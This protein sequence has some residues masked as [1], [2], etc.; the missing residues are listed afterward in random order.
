MTEP[1]KTMDVRMKPA[2]APQIR[3]PLRMRTHLGFG[4]LGGFPTLVFRIPPAPPPPPREELVD[5]CAVRSVVAP[6]LGPVVDALP[7]RVEPVARCA[8]NLF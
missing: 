7:D 4:G 2:T 3:V 6:V 1:T 5:V 8:A